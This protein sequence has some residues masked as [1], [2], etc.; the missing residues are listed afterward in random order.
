MRKRSGIEATK[1]VRR[2]GSKEKD[3]RWTE[4]PEESFIEEE[5]KRRKRATLLVDKHLACFWC[6]KTLRLMNVKRQ[7]K[8]I[9]LHW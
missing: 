7:N 8:I 3:W 4:N 5:R 2:I 6:C 1:G 9:T